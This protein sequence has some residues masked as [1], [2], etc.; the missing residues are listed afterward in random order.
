MAGVAQ[1]SGTGHTTYSLDRTL[2]VT[3][4]SWRWVGNQTNMD[5]YAQDLLDSV[6]DVV[7]EGTIP[8]MRFDERFLTPGRAVA[9]A[10]DGFTTGFESQTMPVVE[11]TLRFQPGQSP[12]YRT[13]LRV[14]NRRNAYSGSAFERPTPEGMHWGTD[15]GVVVAGLAGGGS[16]GAVP[17]VATPWTGRPR[18]RR[19]GGSDDGRRP[20]RPPLTRMERRVEELIRRVL[21][22]ESKVR[23]L[24][25]ELRNLRGF[26][27]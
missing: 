16:I 4:P 27:S 10:G 1:Y 21:T 23:Q 3:V 8:L 15:S 13:E 17:W 2:D 22:L 6:K 20:G 5:A 12:L 9:L 25:Q 14:S 7:I 11:C 24:E 18:H 26:G 19:R